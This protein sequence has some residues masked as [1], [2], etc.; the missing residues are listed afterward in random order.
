VTRKH[1]PRLTD[2]QRTALRH[3]RAFAAQEGPVLSV[4][5]HLDPDSG[6]LHASLR[7]DLTTLQ[8][9]APKGLPVRSIEEVVLVIEP[10][11][12][13]YPMAYVTHTRFVGH[14]HVLNGYA[15][16]LYLDYSREYH[17]DRGV[18][19]IIN[20]LWH[21]LED[22]T[23]ARFDPDTALYHA[24]G[25]VPHLGKDGPTIVVRHPLDT[26]RCV[27]NAFLYQRT[28]RRYDLLTIRRTPND[29]PIPI[30]HLDHDLPL[31]AGRNHL[32]ELLDRI[33]LPAA[34]DADP[35]RL[36]AFLHRLGLAG[37]L[38]AEAIS[39]P[40][41]NDT[42]C[43]HLP[44]WRA[45]TLWNPP[46]VLPPAPRRPSSVF[47]T[48]LA[49]TA[50]K[51]PSGTEVRAIITVPHP[52]GRYRHL[53]GLHLAPQIGDALRAAVQDRNTPTIS[54]RASLTDPQVPMDW[55]RI[56][57]ERD[58]VTQRRDTGRPVTNFQ[59]KTIQIWGLGGIG[60]W[61]AEYVAR[62]APAKLIL[63]DPGLITG[64]ILVRQNYIEA[65]IGDT[66]ADALARRLAGID[67]DLDI[68][69]APDVITAATQHAHETDLIIDATISNA[70]ALILNEIAANPHTAT[71]V[72]VATDT[73]TGT[74]GVLRV[75]AANDQRGPNQ[76]D[77]A[78]CKAILA[79]PELER[80]HAI[81]ADP[82]PGDELVPTKGCSIP[83]FHGSAADLAS[84]AASL[85]T[86]VG[87]HL[88]TKR[89]GTH[90]FGLP[91]TG[92]SPARHWEPAP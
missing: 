35:I 57:D 65:D 17:P 36:A 32:T 80:Y 40:S 69:V 3:L 76:I 66:K 22:A 31:G 1:K 58:A 6:A 90:L 34:F 62:A 89:S 15:L 91:H 82:L 70:V 27:Q 55:T 77:E 48:A 71:L 84:V 29:Q 73:R 44:R 42:P 45:R 23:Q 56:S 87:T 8:P 51:Q 19:G 92:V 24:V 4:T 83:T 67:D 30:I 53:L 10:H 47:L 14:P 64:G 54:V 33:D 16:C 75:S 68:V 7:L 28:E 25:G 86:L 26:T 18:T 38:A 49:A 11:Q 13:Q 74:L 20:R 88:R 2:W 79:N 72:Q 43:P 60:S 81:W 39:Q 85:T 12:W 78:T 5:E 52:T 61:I 21:W 59:D 46:P 63:C 37:T 50:A 41:W 9:V